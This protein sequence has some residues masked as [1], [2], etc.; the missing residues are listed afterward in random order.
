[1]Y[2]N[3][4]TIAN[5]STGCG[6]GIFYSA[7]RFEFNFTP[8]NDFG[9]LQEFASFAIY[10]LAPER[11]RFFTDHGQASFVVSQSSVVAISG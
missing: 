3:K 2:V 6:Y 5:L 9:Y 1:M 11:Y 4:L 7:S 10:V 8:G